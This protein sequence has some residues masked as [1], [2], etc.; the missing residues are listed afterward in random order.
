M[1]VELA[2]SLI[3]ECCTF[4]LGVIYGSPNY[5]ADNFILDHIQLWSENSRCLILG[6]FNA[7]DISWIGHSPLTVGSR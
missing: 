4:I 3:F 5:L 1:I 6:D 7:S 2:K